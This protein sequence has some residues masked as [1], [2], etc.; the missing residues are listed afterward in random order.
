[1]WRCTID[2]RRHLGV[3]RT[4]FA[5]TTWKHGG[6]IHLWVF[7]ISAEGLRESHDIVKHEGHA[8]NLPHVPLG[9]ISVKRVGIG[10]HPSHVCHAA[11][12][13]IRD[14][15]VEFSRIMKHVVRVCS[16]AQ[17]PLRDI[18]VKNVKTCEQFREVSHVRHVPNFDRISDG[19]IAQA[20]WPST[21]VFDQFLTQC[22]LVW[23][24][25]HCCWIGMSGR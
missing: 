15:D 24:L 5:F 2:D 16:T 10:K 9:E 7:P 18:I 6:F 4:N 12:V 19:G 21:T 22:I 25:E 17:V 1:M 3:L 13:P 20:L 23:R 14:V 11:N 8:L